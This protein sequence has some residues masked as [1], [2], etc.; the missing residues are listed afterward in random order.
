MSG[1]RQIDA[2]NWNSGRGRACQWRSAPFCREERGYQY[3]EQSTIFLS[4]VFQPRRPPFWPKKTESNAE[5]GQLP[6]QPGKVGDSRRSRLGGNSAGPESSLRHPQT[7]ALLCFCPL[8]TAFTLR[9]LLSRSPIPGHGDR[10]AHHA[11]AGLLQVAHEASGFP[12]RPVQSISF[13]G[14]L[15]ETRASCSSYTDSQVDAFAITCAYAAYF[16]YA[17]PFFTP[18]VPPCNS[19]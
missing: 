18:P 17:L 12:A 9:L 1:S 10:F 3:I 14:V 11:A 2:E 4:L 8:S 6:L 7:S 15:S 16:R 13:D 5:N 19:P